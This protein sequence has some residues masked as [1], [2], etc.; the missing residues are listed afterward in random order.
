MNSTPE[1]NRRPVSGEGYRF[2]N[3]A[4]FHTTSWVHILDFMRYERAFLARKSDLKQLIEVIE[5]R[6]TQM[7][8]TAILLA[9][10]DWKGKTKPNWT[11]IRLLA[12]QE[13]E[14]VTDPMKL[15]SLGADFMEFQTPTL[16]WEAECEVTGPVDWVLQT[17]YDNRAVP[18][19]ERDATELENG[20]YHSEDGM[21]VVT[22]KLF[23]FM[24]NDKDQ[25]RFP[26]KAA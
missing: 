6:N 11:P 19:T 16:K 4:L 21:K 2:Y 3:Y 22:V 25:W 7:G 12:N 14:L 23:S 18:S 5:T 20:I 13:L 26:P 9:K 10:Y 17:M 15:L 24:A 8:A 1:L